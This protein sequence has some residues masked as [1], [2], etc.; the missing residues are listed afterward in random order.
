MGEEHFA[1][2][3][4][5]LS[6]NSAQLDRR[7]SLRSRLLCLKQTNGWATSTGPNGQSAS[8]T[9]ALEVGHGGEAEQHESTTK[10]ER[11]ES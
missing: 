4:D 7:D 8:E 5:T 1:E 3:N 2:F 11:E 6:P 9:R 10:T